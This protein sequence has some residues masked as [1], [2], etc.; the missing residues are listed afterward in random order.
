MLRGKRITVV[1]PCHNEED[2]I[3]HVL[4]NMPSCVDEVVVVD[5]AST[6]KTAEVAKSLG[7]K[8]VY[9]PRKGYGAAYKAGIPAAT[10]DVVVTMDGDGSYPQE[11]IGEVTEFMLDRDLD[12]VSACRFPLANQKSMNF[13]N[14]IGNMI[15]TSAMFLLYM[16]RIRDSQSGMWFFK[17]SI[18]PLL[19]VTSDGMPFSEEIKIEAIKNRQI[20]F[21]EYH[22]NYHIR[23]GTVKL[24]KWA[25]GFEN[26]IFLVKKRF[27]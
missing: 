11:S 3:A 14:W 9:E 15:L 22:V 12:F 2:G 16:R 5:N 7:A 26:L 10:G 1:I 21:A 27:S 8:V 6:D 4:K 24:R 18:Y 17:R 23:I 25:D 20:K 13:S 19:E